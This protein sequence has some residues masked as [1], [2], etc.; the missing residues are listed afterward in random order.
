MNMVARSDRRWPLLTDKAGKAVCQCKAGV[1]VSVSAE[2]A[3]LHVDLEGL[4]Y[5][6]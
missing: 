6:F 2:S 1:D 4:S 3:A 5:F